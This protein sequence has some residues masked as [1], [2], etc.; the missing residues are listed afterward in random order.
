ML[1]TNV[2]KLPSATWLLGKII[3]VILG[4]DKNARLYLVKTNLVILKRT[5]TKLV[6][7]PITIE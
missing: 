3:E 4:N 2:K 7:L 5:I 6:I 1:L